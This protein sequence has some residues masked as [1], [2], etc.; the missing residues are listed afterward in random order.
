MPARTYGPALLAAALGAVLYLPSLGSGFLAY[1]DPHFILG[2]E[3]VR[4]PSLRAAGAVL[5]AP[6]WGS[7]HPLHIL[8]YALDSLVWGLERPA[9]FHATNV[10]LF[11]ACCALVVLVARSFGCSAR[12]AALAGVLFAVHPSHVESVAWLTGR[13]D[14]LSG[15]FLLLALLVRER[16][17]LAVFFFL[18]ALA[19]KTT[20]AAL[21][22]FLVLDAWL[23][24]RPGE[25]ARLRA[26]VRFVPFL[27]LA[28]GWI[29]IEALA[30]KS[31]GGVK[32]RGGGPLESVAVVLRSLA[33]YPARFVWPHPLT[34]R[35]S[36]GGSPLGSLAVLAFAVAPA[37]FDRRLARAIAFFFLALAPVSNV[38]PLANEVQ[39][40]YLFLPSIAACC[41][42]GELAGRRKWWGLPLAAL[43]VFLLA[44]STAR[45]EGAWRSDA[46]L[47]TAAV[48]A[49]DNPVARIGLAAARMR[50]GKLD[51]AK[52]DVLVAVK[53]GGG[54]LAL[55][56]LAVV[57]ERRG[58]L[59]AAR[60]ALEE[61]WRHAPGEPPVGAALVRLLAREGNVARARSVLGE[62]ESSAPTATS[63]HRARAYVLQVEGDLV[64]AEA[65]YVLASPELET[66]DWLTLAAIER[67]LGRDDRARSAL[68]HALLLDPS[69]R[70]RLA[71]DPVLGPL[72]R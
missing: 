5:A 62:F 71:S 47:W 65:E 31:V 56:A 68:A 10:A 58:D 41:V 8:S 43:A 14:V 59:P 25:E 11:A 42:A 34:P 17:R 18:L 22:P 53:G 40:R 63:T 49:D 60:A 69:V 19:S 67:R 51:E 6:V 55:L 28:A 37:F 16:P 7:Y 44:R 2:P 3:V 46:A 24:R 13:K 38:V 21:A 70:T 23:A 35:P 27:V 36:L 54:T 4:A 1:D 64:H 15:V 20:A 12:G 32:V 33:W 66:D 26:F 61:A 29:V 39:D 9:G 50:E 57:D 48:E 52:V 30:Q 72:L 45:Y